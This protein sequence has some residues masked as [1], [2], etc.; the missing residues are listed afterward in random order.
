LQ[1][2]LEQVAIKMWPIDGPLCINNVELGVSENFV[3]NNWQLQA[4]NIQTPTGV[5]ELD[6][7]ISRFDYDVYQVLARSV[8]KDLT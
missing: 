7:L 8:I 6:G 3:I 5:L 2:A 4:A 1:S